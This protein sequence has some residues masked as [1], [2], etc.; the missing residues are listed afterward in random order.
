MQVAARPDVVGEEVALEHLKSLA[1]QLDVT[2]R[3]V[4]D[5]SSGR[6]AEV[7][8]DASGT[9]RIGI[10]QEGDGDSLPTH[11]HVWCYLDAVDG[12]IKL[13]GLSSK[14]GVLWG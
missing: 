12:T 6:Y 1:L 9:M 11:G 2:I 8:K 10:H 14:P 5:T 13:S 3:L 7:A 4:I